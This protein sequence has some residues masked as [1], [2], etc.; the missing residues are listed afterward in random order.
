VQKIGEIHKMT[1]TVTKTYTKQDDTTFWPWEQ[2]GYSNGLDTAK[3]EG[4]LLS[5]DLSEDGN[6]A[7]TT[8]EWT[9]KSVYEDA[10]VSKNDDTLVSQQTQWNTYMSLNKITCRVVQEDGTVRV[11]NSSTQ[12]FELE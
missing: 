7:T 6:T 12:S 2:T 11:F 5:H 8:Q 1:Y 3:S 9:S 4:R 10:A